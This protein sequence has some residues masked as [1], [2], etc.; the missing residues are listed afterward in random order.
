MTTETLEAARAVA[1]DA[2]LQAGALLRRMAGQ[3]N[4]VRHKGPVD[5]VT[6]A[7]RASERLILEAIRA[8]FPEHAILSE[9]SGALSGADDAPRWLIDPLDGTTN[10]AHGYP[11]YAVSIAL[12]VAAEVVL[13]VV[14]VP[15][16][17][18]LYVAERGRGA[19]LNGQ[20][21][22]VSRTDTLLASLLATGFL[23]DVDTRGRNLPHWE[24]FIHATQGVRRSGSAAI[25]LCHVAAGRLDGY[26]EE[27]LA[28]WDSA[29]GSLMVTEAGGTVTGYDGEPF[30]LDGPNC[31]AS[32]GVIHAAMLR[33]LA[34]G[35]AAL[36]D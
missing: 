17:D 11:L 18:E 36:P 34:Q 7:D 20:P 26:W 29:A 9:E 22:R 21:L 27:G 16:L 15:T 1:T 35:M 8:R 13:G 12:E 33:V 2:A 19:W 14:Y 25:D 24:N 32:N 5:L 28:P 31:V 6:E 4:D 30:R 23:Y 3:V 10:Y